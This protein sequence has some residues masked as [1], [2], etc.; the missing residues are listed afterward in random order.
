MTN[1]EPRK[2]FSQSVVKCGNNKKKLEKQVLALVLIEDLRFLPLVREIQRLSTRSAT[3]H[4]WKDGISHTRGRNPRSSI[5]TRVR[6]YYSF[7][8]KRLLTYLDN[9]SCKSVC[10]ISVVPISRLQMIHSVNTISSCI[11]LISF[12]S[13]HICNHLLKQGVITEYR[14][15]VVIGYMASGH[16]ENSHSCIFLLTVWRLWVWLSK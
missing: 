4:S 7:A 1:Q 11:R 15:S 6:T 2:K 16:E 5:G 9:S 13:V 14:K 8:V 3:L 10:Y 12:E